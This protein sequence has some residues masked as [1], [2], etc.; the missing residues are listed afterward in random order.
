M[1]KL[2]IIHLVMLFLLPLSALAGFVPG[3]E[4]KG[5]SSVSMGKTLTD[6][7]TGMEFV[8]VKGGCFK[9]GSND[10]AS[11]E[12]PLHEVCVDDF[13][14]GKYEVTQA[15]YD[16]LMKGFWGGGN[17]SEFKGK[18]RPVENISWEETQ[19]FIDKLN[20]KS[21]KKY[22][23]PTEAEW[24]YAARS[25]GKKEKWAGTNSE[26]SLGEYAWYSKNSNS[27][28]HPAG[29]KKPN[30]LGLYDMSGNVWE[31]C[32]DRYD[33]GY[34]SQSPRQ[35][36]QGPSKGSDRVIRGGGWDYGPWILRSAN[37]NGGRPGYR[38][39][40]LGFRLVSP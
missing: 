23:L 13:W 19:K 15:Q 26:S 9:M 37:R 30:G 18:N 31:W 6:P 24:E 21:K 29:Q 25:G 14:M 40:N 38:D 3:F 17:R 39:F 36:P 8:L 5:H 27:Q 7:I 28:T 20:S 34:Y 11:D 2:I 33:T 32:S 1:M 10:G 16:K 4:L 22:R 12:K 35:N